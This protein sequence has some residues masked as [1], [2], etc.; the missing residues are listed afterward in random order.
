MDNHSF[1]LPDIS[2]TI[3][4][5]FGSSFSPLGV[6]WSRPYLALMSGLAFG[7]S[8]RTAS[9]GKAFEFLK[10]WRL[11]S[12]VRK[13]KGSTMDQPWLVVWLP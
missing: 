9:R 2:T 12:E 1:F 5:M 13:G 3:R 11:S 10:A 7:D 4:V 8:D 6:R